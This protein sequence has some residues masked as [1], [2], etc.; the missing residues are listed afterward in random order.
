MSQSKRAADPHRLDRGCSCCHIPYPHNNAPF[1]NMRVVPCQ[2]CHKKWVPETLLATVQ[3][4]VTLLVRGRGSFVQA[5]V[6]SAVL[7]KQKG[8]SLAQVISEILPILQ[9]ELHRQLAINLRTIG[10]NAAFGVDIQVQI[11]PTRLMAVASA[12]AMNLPAL[13]QPQ[14]LQIRRNISIVDAEDRQLENDARTLESIAQYNQRTRDWPGVSGAFPKDAIPSRTSRQGSPRKLRA[15]PRSSP[16]KTPQSIAHPGRRSSPLLRASSTSPS[17]S[18][19][20][21][22]LQAPPL[23]LSDRGRTRKPP[24]AKVLNPQMHRL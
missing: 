9:Y 10:M 1:K 22:R 7:A 4:P 23:L 18:P 2:V 21:R 17:S 11:G 6:T 19:R 16:R 12:T 13:P 24:L 20:Q 15:S 14:P 8:E 5:R 3:P